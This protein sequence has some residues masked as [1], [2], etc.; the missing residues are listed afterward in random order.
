LNHHLLWSDHLAHPTTVGFV[1]AMM[2]L[3]TAAAKSAQLPFSSWLPRAMEGPT[4]S[5]AIFYGSLAV[6]I[7]VFLLLRTSHFWESQIVVRWIIGIL[8][9]VTAVMAYGMARVQASIKS[10]IA[11]S[12]I[13]QIGLIF[14]EIAAG[15][16][17]FAL[18]HIA[19]NA[20][21]R[22]YQLLVSPSVVSYKIREQFYNFIP[23][24]KTIEDSLPK[25]IENSLYLLS[26]KGTVNGNSLKTIV[27]Q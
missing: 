3:L 21:L 23:R 5:S 18:I 8:G 20:F 27:V 22:T 25:K 6:H 24:H 17:V 2:I 26:L 15:L 12:S 14:M 1:I 11:Y 10:Q 19:G 7:G 9:L 13:A 4:P 16:E